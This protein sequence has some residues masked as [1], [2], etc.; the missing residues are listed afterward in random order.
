MSSKTPIPK[1]LGEPETD[2]KADRERLLLKARI[3]TL[4]AGRA[5]LEEEVETLRVDSALQLQDIQKKDAMIEELRTTTNLTRSGIV[6]DVQDSDRLVEKRVQELKVGI[7]ADLE[8]RSKEVQERDEIIEGLR[9]TNQNLQLNHANT[10]QIEQ[11]QRQ[12]DIVE[13]KFQEAERLANTVLK[14]MD[15]LLVVTENLTNNQ[16]PRQE[17]VGDVVGVLKVS[18]QHANNRS[19][20]LASRANKDPAPHVKNNA[21]RA[22]SEAIAI[23]DCYVKLAVLAGE[24][25]GD[26]EKARA[27][28]KSIRRDFGHMLAST[29]PVLQVESTQSSRAKAAI[30]AT[31]PAAPQ[32]Q[33]SA[34]RTELHVDTKPATK[35]AQFPVQ[36][37]LTTRIFSNPGATSKE[38]ART[39]AFMLESCKADEA[40][41]AKEEADKANTKSKV[42]SK[43]IADAAPGK[44]V[45]PGTPQPSKASAELQ[46]IPQMMSGKLSAKWGDS[47]EPD[48][49]NQ[50]ENKAS[51]SSSS[52][53]P[54]MVDVPPPQASPSLSNQ[55]GQVARNET[56]NIGSTPT[57]AEEG[58]AVQK[59]LSELVE[60]VKVVSPTPSTNTKNSQSEDTA[61]GDTEAGKAVASTLAAP[62]SAR[63]STSAILGKRNLEDE[64][65]YNPQSN[66]PKRTKMGKNKKLRS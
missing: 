35:P 58:Q 17:R 38:F 51:E 9:K 64:V 15:T 42:P 6:A 63:P 49:L 40:Q 4:E 2:R 33:N 41:R 18:A 60:G 54:T 37:V 8:A 55:S 32:D 57:T 46:K 10:E 39:Y 21:E 16:G 65:I 31:P 62:G 43:R 28:T 12:N 3:A 14:R 20:Y 24:S 29:G 52:Q 25:S 7:M 66:P 59:E 47:E 36:R 56:E 26:L 27:V 19:D 22:S 5:T 61:P 13:D 34:S 30:P 23:S 11:L 48:H 1:G 44:A 53:Q 45:E 50:D